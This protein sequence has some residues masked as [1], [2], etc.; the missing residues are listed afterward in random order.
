MIGYIHCEFPVPTSMGSE[1]LPVDEDGGFIV[2]GTEVEEN[3]ISLRPGGRDLKMRAIP[4]VYPHRLHYTF[5]MLA[6]AKYVKEIYIPDSALSRQEGTKT[7]WL[8][9]TPKGGALIPSFVAF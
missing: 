1:L 4:V 9:S 8:R 5:I 3:T 2:N 6:H 7:D